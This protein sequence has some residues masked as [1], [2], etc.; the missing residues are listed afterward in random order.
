MQLTG[1]PRAGP[2]AAA[3]GSV[4]P[5]AAGNKPFLSNPVGF[6]R[7]MSEIAER[8]PIVRQALLRRAE[9]STG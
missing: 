8:N 5:S 2:N 6:D 3:T 9:G 1:T 7:I 4:E